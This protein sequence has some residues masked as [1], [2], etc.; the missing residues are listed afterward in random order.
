[1]VRNCESFPG[2]DAGYFRVGVKT[3]PENKILMDALKEV[4]Y[5]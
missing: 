5:G 2:L 4:L 1:M 3:R